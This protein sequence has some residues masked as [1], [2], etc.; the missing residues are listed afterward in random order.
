MNEQT[1]ISLLLAGPGVIA[2]LIFAP[3]VM[4]LFYSAKFAAATGILRWICLGA[5]L[6]VITWP[7][8]F[9][10]IAKGAQALFFWC[11][12]AWVVVSVGLALVCVTTFGLNGAGIAFFGSYLFHL[13]LIY[14]VVHRL[15]AFHFSVE[16]KHTAILLLSLIAVVFCGIYLLPLLPAL[17]LG[18]IAL[19]ASSMYSVRILLTLVWAQRIPRRVRLVLAAL[20]IRFAS[21][22]P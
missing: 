3:L 8:G 10:I 7:M 5:T 19:V 4:A 18:A 17:T 21:R 15:S 16:N 6:Q 12:V 9:I 11:E 20:D 22:N 1:R 14:P 13:F 2:T